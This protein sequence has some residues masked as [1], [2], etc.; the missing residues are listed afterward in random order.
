MC[1]TGWTWSSSGTSLPGTVREKKVGLMDSTV[2]TSTRIVLSGIIEW[3]IFCCIA[4]CDTEWWHVFVI[5]KTSIC[6]KRKIKSGN[7]QT[8]RGKSIQTRK[9]RLEKFLF[10]ICEHPLVWWILWERRRTIYHP[11]AFLR[12]PRSTSCGSNKAWCSIRNENAVTR[13]VSRLV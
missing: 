5:S 3:L 13:L 6:K 12:R 7:P 9:I 2:G 1:Q 8:F 10:R 4:R 11:I